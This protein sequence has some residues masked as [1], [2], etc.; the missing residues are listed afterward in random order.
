M[1]I[2]PNISKLVN[3]G[4][5]LAVWLWLAQHIKAF[6]R[7]ACQRK[8]RQWP[9]PPNQPEKPPAPRQRPACASF[10]C[11]HSNTSHPQADQHA[12][13]NCRCS[14]C[15]GDVRKDSFPVIVFGVRNHGVIDHFG[16]NF[17][18]IWSIFLNREGRF[19]C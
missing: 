1:L 15:S 13:T 3:N 9:E 4:C 11:A 18:E 12:E 7:Q 8:V 10:C 5:G 17:R 19:L 14:G 6:I 2:N 16:L